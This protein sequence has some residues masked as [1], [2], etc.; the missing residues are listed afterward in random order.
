MMADSSD[1]VA[2]DLRQTGAFD[3]LLLDDLRE[4][5][6]EGSDRE[7]ARW[8]REVASQLSLNLNREFALEL[9]R[10]YMSEV[11][12]RFPTWDTR[13]RRAQQD[14]ARLLEELRLLVEQLEKPPRDRLITRHFRTEFHAWIDRWFDHKRA[15][16]TL[17]LDAMNLD[18]GEG[19]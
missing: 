10:G 6:D 11:L 17:L 16:N 13:L 2:E 15:E 8:I 14:R 19:E 18:V 1:H 4:L 7:N 9:K 5:L 12:D 3:Q